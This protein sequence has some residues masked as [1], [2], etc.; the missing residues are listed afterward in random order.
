MEENDTLN[1]Q[2]CLFL[3]YATTTKYNQL[4]NFKTHTVDVSPLLYHVILLHSQIRY[5]LNNMY[6]CW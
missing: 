1:V 6:T 4:H 2:L 3:E 5:S